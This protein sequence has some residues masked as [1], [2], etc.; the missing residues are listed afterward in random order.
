M[1]LKTPIYDYHEELG[2][3]IVPF[4]GFL[5]PVQY[6]TGVITEHKAVREKAG[7]FDVSHMGEV[8]ISGKDALANVNMLLTND[9]TVMEAGKCRYSPMCS[10]EGGIVDDLI[11]YK[12]KDDSYLI[13]VNASNT[14]KDFAWMKAHAFGDV[15]M[16][17]ISDSV[18]QAA[19]QGPLAKEIISRVCNADELPS[20]YYSFTQEMQVCG[21]KSLV[22]KTGYTGEDGYEIYCAAGEG[23]ELFRRLLEAG[24]DLG[25]IPCGLGARDTLRLEAAMPLYGHEMTDEITPLEAN[26]GFAVKMSKEDFIGKKAL[27]EKGPVQRKRVGLKITG[28]G[29]AREHC[30]IYIGENKVGITTSG[31][32]CPHLNYAVAM[33]LVDIS[34]AEIGT[35]VETD[36]RGRRIEAEVVALPFYKREK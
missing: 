9:F 13:I 4:G 20:K 26:L 8:V 21:I 34:A 19:L 17:N 31:T 23:A 22:S 18:A 1:D 36:V 25:L 29:I 5:L 14:E 32:F 28:R 10:E 33:G 24:A 35:K 11:V 30:D 7:L 15:S 12:I 27:E 6:K 16:E 2:G 3:K